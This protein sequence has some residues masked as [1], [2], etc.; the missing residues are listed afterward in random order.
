MAIDNIVVNGAENNM[1]D[2]KSLLNKEDDI[3]DNNNK[4]DYDKLTFWKWLFQ[5]PLSKL[6]FIYFCVGIIA[7]PALAIFNFMDADTAYI[8]CGG[9]IALNLFGLKHFYTLI[10]LKKVH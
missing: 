8:I 3:N 1:D 5:K 2:T 4:K 10:G 7:V 6:P 9:Y